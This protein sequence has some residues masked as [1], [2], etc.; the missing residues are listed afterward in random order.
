MANDETV[1]AAAVQ[2]STDDVDI[3]PDSSKAKAVAPVRNLYIASTS[4]VGFTLTDGALRLVVLLYADS[5]G[6]S[7]VEIA[8][9]FSLYEAS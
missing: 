6:F 2:P 9:M 5:L 4:Y 3:A 1:T 7:A 8:V